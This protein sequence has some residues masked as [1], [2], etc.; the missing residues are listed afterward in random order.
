MANRDA[1]KIE[2]MVCSRESARE[3]KEFLKDVEKM[4]LDFK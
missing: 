3:E 1:Q 4:K 2:Y